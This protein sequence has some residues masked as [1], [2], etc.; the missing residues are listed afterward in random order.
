MNERYQYYDKKVLVPASRFLFI[1]TISSK[2]NHV[3]GGNDR[4]SKGDYFG[5]LFAIGEV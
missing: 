5:L 2:T 4:L 1:A 3:C